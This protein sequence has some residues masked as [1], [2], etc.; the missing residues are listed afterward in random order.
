MIKNADTQPSDVIGMFT[1]K[2]M[3]VAFFSPTETGL[4]K[5]IIDAIAPVRGLLRDSGIHDFDK[6]KKGTEHKVIIRAFLVTDQKTIETKLSLYRPETKDGDPRLWVYRLKE[7]CV[8]GNLIAIVPIDKDSVGIIN[9]SDKSI[10]KQIDNSTTPIGAIADKFKKSSTSEVATELLYKLRDIHRMGFIESM[11]AG[12]TGVGYTIETLL[13]IQ[14]NSSKKPDYKGIEIKSSRAR[15]KSTTRS[16][17]FGKAPNWKISPLNA[18][19]IMDAYGYESRGKRRLNCTIKATKENKQTLKLDADR[20]DELL[21]V[22]GRASGRVEDVAYWEN[23]V[24]F[25]RLLEKHRETFW[26]KAKTDRS[27]KIERFHY[28]EVV[29]TK[30]PILSNMMYLIADGV[31]S[32]E[33]LLTQLPNR[34]RDH[35][36]LFKIHPRD[37][38][39][40]IPT[41]GIYDLSALA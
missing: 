30:K 5:S 22:T 18:Q 31:I 40:L 14:A 2:N 20:N 25:Q 6:Q 24:L 33:F 35:G 27:G 8:A 12:D 10:T 15:D 4:N 1:E 34:I 38:G 41:I 19:G 11:R 9:V 39:K 13:G 32:L 21:A 29:H 3:P 37:I 17:L 36:Y 16:N 26:V 28:F 23:R 7:Y